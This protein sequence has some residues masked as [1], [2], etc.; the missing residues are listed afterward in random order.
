MSRH[1][2]S[3]V[4]SIAITS[5]II[6]ICLN[7]IHDPQL[8]KTVKGGLIL[9]FPVLIIVFGLIY[10]VALKIIGTSEQNPIAEK[11][12]NYLRIK[13]IK[14]MP[15]LCEDCGSLNQIELLKC[16]CGNNYDEE[17]HIN[18][19]PQVAKV[20][21]KIKLC[22]S[23]NK[24]IPSFDSFCMYCGEHTPVISTKD[25]KE[26]KKASKWILAISI[27]FIIFGTISGFLNKSNANKILNDLNQYQESQKI[28]K[29]IN[30]KEYT[31]G[32]LKKQISKE[33]KLVFITNYFLAAIMFVLF[34]WS[35]KA[36]FPAMVTALCI[37]LAT[38]ALNAII[39]PVTIF[40]GIIIKIIFISSL[41]AGIRASLAS[42]KT[43]NLENLP[44]TK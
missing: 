11:I 15:W 44:V 30:G 6:L 14:K 27:L 36:P 13:E 42:R 1:A 17:T 19:A 5:L 29:L 20:L 21:N 22:P 28:N 26:M 43:K 31:V 38:I 7:I 16:K 2:I 4:I 33:V 12:Q 10:A 24:E 32:A 40:Q 8:K 35:Y 3:V 39:S 25:K 18:T 34:L 41:V 37:Y 9:G 23:C